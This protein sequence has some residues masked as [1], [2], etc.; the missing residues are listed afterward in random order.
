MTSRELERQRPGRAETGEVDYSAAMRLRR[1]LYRARRARLG[2]TL[3][4]VALAVVVGFLVGRGT[5][6]E[7]GFEVRVTL[8]QEAL[9]LVFDADGI[10][11]SAT[12]DRPSVSEALVALQRDD[13]PTVVEASVADWLAAY[14]NVLARVAAVE[15]SPEGRPVQR[16]FINAITLSRDAVVVLARAAEMEDAERRAGL[17]TEVARLRVR[18]EQMVQ[19]GRAG[20]MD[21]DG[22]S[23]DVSPLPELPEF[24]QVDG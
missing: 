15:V 8:E 6:P 21:L 3:L 1:A 12:G 11:T 13:D 18:G 2:R 23:G 7:R 14:D 4:L 20:I 5:A 9:P 19:S 16:Q 17:L 10:W 24:P 22:G